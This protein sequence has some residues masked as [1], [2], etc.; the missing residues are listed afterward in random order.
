MKVVIIGGVAGGASTAA[1]LRRLDENAEIKIFEKSSYVSFANCGLPYHIGN[2]I[3]EREKLLLES[4]VSFKNKFNIEVIVNSEVI[5]INREKKEITVKDL[6]KN[7]EYT[8]NYDKFS[9]LYINKRL[10]KSDNPTLKSS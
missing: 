6:K 2:V 3:K 7:T 8:E 1:R 5:S 10:T 9:F 4:P